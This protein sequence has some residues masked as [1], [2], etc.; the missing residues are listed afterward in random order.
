MTSTPRLDSKPS[1]R[2]A[3]LAG[4]LGAVGAFA[5]SAIGRPRVALGHDPD[6]VALGILNVTPAT[7]TISNSTTSADILS[8]SNT[9]AGMG[10]NAFSF[11]NTGVRA[12]SN[13]VAGQN[14]AALFASS[15]SADSPQCVGVW[16]TAFD[17]AGV[18][19]ESWESDGVS[20][21]ANGSGNGVHGEAGSGWAGYF[22]G[23]VLTTKY[24]E[25]VGI[26]TPPAP[27]ASRA[28][29]FVRVNAS[30]KTQLCVRFPTGA[31]KVLATEP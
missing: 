13:A 20:G 14:V 21:K 7:T 22:E 28:R 15:G 19:G 6:D 18:F 29:L 23:K 4:A 17:N 16:G 10:L 5:A 27:S 11:A 25:I 9:H 31:V 30:G 8:L 24:H 1:S 26:N 3:L 12:A 2:R